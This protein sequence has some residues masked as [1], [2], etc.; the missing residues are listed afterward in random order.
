M[1]DE[2]AARI[3]ANEALFREVN[4][5]IEAMNERFGGGE[6]FTIVCECGDGDCTERISVPVDV[7]ERIRADAELFLVVPG[8]EIPAVEEVT[9][10]GD[11]YRI[12]RKREGVPEAVAEETDPRR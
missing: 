9:E 1:N 7:Y 11:G 6:S 4:E 5:Q 3:G 10:E 12:V 8:H 2:R